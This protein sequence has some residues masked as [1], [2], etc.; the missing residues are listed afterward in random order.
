MKLIHCILELPIHIRNKIGIYCIKSFWKQYIPIT[1]KVPNWYYYK[2]YI[3]KELFKSISNNIHFMH[4]EFNT[5]PQY[6]QYILGCQCNYCINYKKNNIQ[7]TD[8]LYHKQI[9]DS[10]YFK[11]NMPI[12]DTYWNDEY[13]SNVTNNGYLNFIYIYNPLFDIQ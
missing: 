7:Y 12:T 9:N 13:I 8:K 1:N 3:E 6:K 5:L 10:N 2:N 11:N 4:L